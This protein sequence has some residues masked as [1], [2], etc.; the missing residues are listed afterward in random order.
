MA[1]FLNADGD[2][3]LVCTSVGCVHLADRARNVC[4][5]GPQSEISC[6]P[7]LQG[8]DRGDTV[9]RVPLHLCLMDRADEDQED[10]GLKSAP[11]DARLCAKI[12]R[13]RSRGRESPWWPY[14]ASLPG[15][16]VDHSEALEAA[17]ADLE[18]GPMREAV[19]RH[20]NHSGCRDLPIASIRIPCRAW[21]GCLSPD[22]QGSESEALHGPLLVSGVPHQRPEAPLAPFHRS[23]RV[24]CRARA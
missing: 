9:L 19:A 3:G 6:H 8:I 13:E 1:L 12:L 14:L 22:A 18:Y 23:S 20:N 7:L 15:H 2:R 10:E 16:S 5:M 21:H 24:F 4:L 17:A 11:W